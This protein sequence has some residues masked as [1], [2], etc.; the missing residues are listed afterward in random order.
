MSA[1]QGGSS[2]TRGE[3]LRMPPGPARALSPGAP[4]TVQREDGFASRSVPGSP[5]RS[6]ANPMRR[7][8]EVCESPEH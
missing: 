2:V 3:S 6:F 1:S 8:R 7:E 4:A 5:R